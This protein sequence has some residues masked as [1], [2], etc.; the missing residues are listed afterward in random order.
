MR[1]RPSRL[2]VFSD[3]EELN[4]GTGSNTPWFVEDVLKHEIRRFQR[5][6]VARFTVKP[7]D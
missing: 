4:G 7:G 5:E 6:P 3:D 1:S 2:T